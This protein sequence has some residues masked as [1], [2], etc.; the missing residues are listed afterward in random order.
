M[1]HFE[2]AQ[3]KGRM[4]ESLAALMSVSNVVNLHADE[5]VADVAPLVRPVP[6]GLH[7]ELL[8]LLTVLETDLDLE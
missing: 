8:A 1:V 4:Y 5:E 3:F 2:G 6:V 7:D